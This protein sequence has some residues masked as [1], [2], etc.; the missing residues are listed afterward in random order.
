MKYAE[1]TDLYRQK[2]GKWISD[3]QELEGGGV[4]VTV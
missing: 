4:G 2:A 1:Y 3:S